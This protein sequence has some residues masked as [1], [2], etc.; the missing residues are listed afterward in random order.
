VFDEQLRELTA[1]VAERV[2]EM[3]IGDHTP[4][5]VVRPACKRCSLLDACQPAKL[6]RPP[7][8]VSWLAVQVR[9]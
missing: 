2:R 4:A 9:P 6:E 3:L 8:V 5:P 7:S 1:Q